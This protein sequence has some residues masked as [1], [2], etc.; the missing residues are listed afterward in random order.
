MARHRQRL[1]LRHPRHARRRP[2][3]PM[4]PASPRGAGDARGRPLVITAHS[5]QIASDLVRAPARAGPAPRAPRAHGRS[6][7][8]ARHR[9][10]GGPGAG[11]HRQGHPRRRRPAPGDQL[12]RRTAPGRQRPLSSCALAEMLGRGGRPAWS[13]GCCPRRCSRPGVRRRPATAPARADVLGGDFYDAVETPTARVHAVIGDVCGHGPDEAALGVAL[14][15]AW[16]TLVLG[17]RRR[18]RVLPKLERVLV[19]RAHG[20]RFR[21]RVRRPVA[22]DRRGR[23]GRP[24]TRRR[25]CSAGAPTDARG[26]GPG[27]RWASSTTSPWPDAARAPARGAAA[28]TDGLIEGRAGPARSP[29]GWREGSRR[30]GRRRRDR[31]PAR[32][33]GVAGLVD[34]RRGAQRRRAARRRGV[35]QLTGRRRRGRC[36]PAPLHRRRWLALSVG[37]FAVAAWSRPALGSPAGVARDRRPEGSRPRGPARSRRPGPQRPWSTRGPASAATP[38]SP[39]RRSSS[40]T[41]GARATAAPSALD[42]LSP[43][44]RRRLR[45]DLALSSPPDRRSGAPDAEPVIARSRAPAPSNEQDAML[46]RASAARGVRAAFPRHAA[47]AVER[48]DGRDELSPRRPGDTTSR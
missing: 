27:R 15:V 8:P 35:L 14:R 7:R 48:G 36:A 18:R 32:T 40:R 28:V 6:R 37:A 3:M 45:Y 39:G 44:D 24:A 16:R 19:A 17:R 21:D 26:G 42:A 22:P 12:R 25:C 41:T 29:G 13:A 10:R 33:P 30:G 31:A 20:T 4:R 46:D 9:R 43:D 38:S 34:V 47:L 5:R 23:S 11:L 2:S 1:R